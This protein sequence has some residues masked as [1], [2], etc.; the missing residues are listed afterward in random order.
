VKRAL[1]LALLLVVVLS[2]ACHAEDY[3]KTPLEELLPLIRIG[4]TTFTDVAAM[5]DSGDY[6]K[7]TPL[8]AYTSFLYE[9]GSSLRLTY[10]YYNG[11]YRV[12]EISL[13]SDASF[14]A[15]ASIVCPA[16]IIP[17]CTTL[18]QLKANANVLD[19]TDISDNSDSIVV[20]IEHNGVG[21]CVWLNKYGNEYVC[22]RIYITDSTSELEKIYGAE[23]SDYTIADFREL[24][25]ME[26]G[27]DEVV[28]AYPG[29]TADT[30]K[31]TFTTAPVK[32]IIYL[33]S[34]HT[35]LV[36]EFMELDGEWKLA[37]VCWMPEY[38]GAL[39]ITPTPDDGKEY[40][41]AMY[42]ESLEWL[43]IG[44]TTFSEVDKRYFDHWGYEV[45]QDSIDFRIQDESGNS[46]DL[47]FVAFG[48]ERVLYAMRHSGMFD[49][50]VRPRFRSTY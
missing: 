22:D 33:L 12:T 31:Y 39:G 6:W 49:T 29:Y 9:D 47:F 5:P 4:E 32:A 36:L 34:D 40:S 1:M 11:D 7:L 14:S 43:T 35:H 27:Y 23:C 19:I 45:S 17:G 38:E 37:G 16:D 10:R 20:D 28:S 42:A 26:T 2:S 30:V 15:E 44:C 25:M 18:S 46:V 13:D 41:K 50:N 8:A 48:D 3:C 21:Y 24:K